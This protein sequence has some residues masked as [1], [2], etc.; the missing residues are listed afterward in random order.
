MYGLRSGWQV[1]VVPDYLDDRQVATRPAVVPTWT[2]QGDGFEIVPAADGI[3]AVL[4]AVGTT[5]GARARLTVAVS[6]DISDS[7]DLEVTAGDV[8][9]VDLRFGTPTPIGGAV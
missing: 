2:L 9:S 7:E 4:R 3:T 1:D 5:V 6:L 8:A